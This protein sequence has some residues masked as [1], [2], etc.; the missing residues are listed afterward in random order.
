MHID[1]THKENDPPLAGGTYMTKRYRERSL[2][3]FQKEFST[4]EACAQH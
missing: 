1:L 2:L 3:D 4:E